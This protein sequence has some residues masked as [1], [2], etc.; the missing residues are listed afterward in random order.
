MEGILANWVRT[1]DITS[2][3]RPSSNL[4]TDSIE[5][6]APD[7]EWTPRYR[8]RRQPVF[9][10]GSERSG[11]T[12]LRLMLDHHPEIAFRGESEFFV[13][14]IRPDGQWPAMADYH[15]FLKND[16]IFRLSGLTVDESLSFPDLVDRFLC[17]KAI[18]NH[19]RVVGATVHFGFRHLPKL[20][21]SARY[22]YLYRDGRDVANSLLRLGWAATPYDAAGWWLRAE[23]EWETLR[24]LIKHA[25]CMEIRF[26]NLIENP[27]EELTRICAFVGTPFD[28]AMLDY[29]KHANYALPDP[30]E[31]A[32]WRSG[33]QEREIQQIETLIW[34]RLQARGY[35]PSGLPRLRV[36][37]ITRGIERFG[38]RIKL[39][40]RRC[41][42]Y[43]A[44]LVLSE[45][46]F[47]R[48]R[49]KRW[50]ARTRRRIDE[51]INS[52]LK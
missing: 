41:R 43:G 9:L 47:R 42:D 38:S 10:V 27:V 52:R 16:R 3:N 40:R 15:A 35:A 4:R 8:L 18:D 24:R 45:V 1:P 39:L 51:I 21:P 32:K 26:E 44:R 2:V 5:D 7:G 29:A 48:L 23:E 11:T 50:H 14:Q 36:S 46:L 20:W 37:R 34:D 28:Y 30:S 19:K 17:Q 6:G 25:A 33:L 49:I 31:S 13:S 22:L 12:L